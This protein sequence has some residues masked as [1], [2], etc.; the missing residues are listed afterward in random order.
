MILGFD[1]GNT[2]TTMGIYLPHDMAPSRDYRYTTMKNSAVDETAALILSFLRAHDIIEN[3]DQAIEG[4]VVSSVVPEINSTYRQIAE[5]YFKITPVILSHQSRT[6]ISITYDDHTQLGIDRIVN[7]EA[8]YSN[9][10]I[11]AIIIDMGT[12][13][14]ISVISATGV[15]EGGL[16]APGLQTAVNALSEKASQLFTVPIEKPSSILAK[17]TRDALIS[18]SFYGWTCMIDGFLAK[19]NEE[20]GRKNT[21]IL[22][23]GLSS[24]IGPH[25]EGN[26]IIDSQLTMKGLRLLY[27]LNKT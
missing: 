17:N 26:I 8:A 16:I 1:I 11:D 12:A 7:C 14:T 23:G 21:I 9:Y 15:F 2:N 24:V 25:L 6:T 20:T 22:T 3:H 5:K 19:I 13:M 18:G 10:G 27:D 4:I